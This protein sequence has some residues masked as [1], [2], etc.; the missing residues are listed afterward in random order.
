MATRTLSR[1]LGAGDSREPPKRESE[2]R[3]QFERLFS[4]KVVDIGCA[5]GPNNVEIQTALDWIPCRAGGPMRLK[6]ITEA[7][8]GEKQ[9]L[10]QET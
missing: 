8:S 10:T 3:V 2:P 4:P 1:A 9:N 6:F 7:A 5:S